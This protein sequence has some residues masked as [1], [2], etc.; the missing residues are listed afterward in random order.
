MAYLLSKLPDE[1]SESLKS[2]ES[3]SLVTPVEFSGGSPVSNYGHITHYEIS[4]KHTGN[5]VLLPGLASNTK[6][7]PLM[8]ACRLWSLSHNYNVFCLDHFLG[9]FKPEFSE[10]DA[11]NNSYEQ[12]MNV[13]TAGLN[14]ISTMSEGK[15]TALL[16]HSFGARGGIDYFNAKAES[17]QITNFSAVALFAPF[18]SKEHTD[19]L[20]RT[21]HKGTTASDEEL[22]EL[23]I[24]FTNPNNPD[25][26]NTHVSFY[27]SMLY[28]KDPRPDMMRK[29]NMDT[30]FV[31]GGRD[32]RAPAAVHYQL[33]QE[34]S[35]GPN[36][37][38]FKYVEFPASN[39]SFF[40]QH[41]D[42]INLMRLVKSLRDKKWHPKQ[43]LQYQ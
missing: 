6:I 25:K 32:H 15:W 24:S 20:I 4:S 7:D 36:G 31:T 39:H 33:Y 3:K 26:Q 10:T 35:Q 22:R 14:M 28:S 41:K 13:I 5:I 42:Y 12:F 27:P 37:H 23:P 18:A 40:D 1:I 16:A 29:W 9:D 34:L 38:M 17:D 30:I 8:N 19:R 43:T 11:K 21:R 2:I